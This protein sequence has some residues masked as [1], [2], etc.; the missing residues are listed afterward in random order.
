[1]AVGDRR[2]YRLKEIQPRHFYQTGQKAGLGKRDMDD[3]F[4]DLLAKVDA[5]LAT[6]AE[7]AGLAGVPQTTLEPIR[8]GV[9]RRIRMIEQ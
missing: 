9:K 8:D 5:A 6:V 4:A 7:Q 2:H 3:L 1:M